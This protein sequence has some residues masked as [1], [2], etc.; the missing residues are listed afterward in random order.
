MSNCVVIPGG[1]C[2]LSAWSCCH[3]SII[4]FTL[5]LAQLLSHSPELRAGPH[6]HRQEAVK[7][8][9]LSKNSSAS[10]G[11]LTLLSHITLRQPCHSSYPLRAWSHSPSR[12]HLLQDLNPNTKNPK[13]ISPPNHR[14]RHLYC[15]FPLNFSSKS[16]TLSWTTSLPGRLVFRTVTM[17]I[18]M[19]S[20]HF[21]PTILTKAWSTS[22]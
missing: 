19:I 21:E 5:S 11:P 3:L 1:P 7:S 12:P 6:T 8:M 22:I 17:A 9:T 20:I 16:P 2:P 10:A 4:P 14:R 13:P 15:L 18:P